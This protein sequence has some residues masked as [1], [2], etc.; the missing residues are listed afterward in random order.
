MVKRYLSCY[1]DE[2]DEIIKKLRRNGMRKLKNEM[3]LS[4]ILKRMRDYETMFNYLL[5]ERQRFLLKF[6]DKNVIDSDSDLI[7]L[8]SAQTLF[9]CETDNE[10][11]HKSIRQHVMV[12][13]LEDE[14]IRNP[15]CAFR[16]VDKDLER[17]V[18]RT[19]I[20]KTEESS[21]L[22]EES[23]VIDSQRVHDVRDEADSSEI[24]PDIIGQ[25]ESDD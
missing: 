16:F 3:D 9:S 11:R 24:A 2:R 6:N 23:S 10:D 20:K 8:D 1:D 5:T 12:K 14:D 13:I 22:S 19:L 18:G 17:G 25:S 7:S 15:D 4:R 21:D